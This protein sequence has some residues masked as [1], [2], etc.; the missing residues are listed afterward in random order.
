[1]QYTYHAAAIRNVNE[2]EKRLVIT[3]TAIN[4]WRKHML[5]CVQYSRKWPVCR[6]CTISSCRTGQIDKLAAEV[7][8]FFDKK[9]I[10]SI[11]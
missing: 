10:I 2:L 1:M 9:C 5:T 7:L 11:K 3:D 4:E 6:T 8:T